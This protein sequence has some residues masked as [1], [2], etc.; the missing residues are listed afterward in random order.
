MAPCDV[1]V[2]I[3]ARV[4]S[5]QQ[6]DANTIGSQVEALKARVQTDGYVLDEELC[7]IDEGHSGGTL[8]R[9]ALERLR[10]QAAA[11]AVD[12]LY[13][14]S[15]DRLARNYPYQ[16]L[17]VDELQRQGVEITFLNHDIGRTPEEKLLLQVQGMVAEYER[18]KI[19]E[20]SRR[21]KRHA[22]RSGAVNVLSGAPY[23]YRYVGKYE[24]AGQ[25][26][27][28]VDDRQA[29]VVIQIFSWMALERCSLAEICRRLK[30]RGVPSPKGKNFW[31]RT[32]VWGLLQNRAYVGQAQFGK[33]RVGPSRPRLR[34]QRGKPMQP[35]RGGS[36]Y[37][38][39]AEERV[40]IPVPAIVSEDLFATVAEQLQE[41]RRRQRA[42]Q[43]GSRYLLQGLLVCGHCGY[44][45][46]GKPLSRSARKGKRRDYA[47]YRCV[48]TD[49]YR[50]G[51][52]RVCKNKQCRTDVLDQAVWEDVCGLLA[53][54]ERVRQEYERRLRGTKNKIGRPT[55]QLARL[56]AKTRQGLARLIDAYQEGYLEREEFEPRIAKTKERLSQLEKEAKL[57]AEREAESKDLGNVIGHL[58]SF[59]ERV[60]DGLK[61]AD[62][63]TRREILRALIKHVEV[64]EDVIRV[65]YKVSPVPFDRGPIRG[66][67]QDCWRGG[68]P[69]LRRPCFRGR[70]HPVVH[71]A[72]FQPLVDE[73]E[74][75]PV[76]HA[77]P[78]HR[79]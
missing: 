39:T 33:T 19:L 26:R 55:E 47:Y 17:L 11:G 43:R 24:G 28:E 58:Q 73:T 57:V 16:V 77:S 45:Y 78:Q 18:A 52:Q 48:G 61:D 44:A 2:A 14:H 42:S 41:N 69:A 50:F 8:L 63:S 59:A 23:G 68:H 34:P 35:R 10:D 38:T 15:P 22:A 6:A 29:E 20:R 51:G 5:K 25:A 7:F 67:S 49:A 72:R 30:D 46:Y 40:S 79:P 37:D 12:R 53:N 62:W 65:V 4:S 54:P 13:V 71:D 1:R 76:P 36:T 74:H 70:Q 60:R 31:D 64:G 9:P 27:Y 66:H 56:I 3:Y 32:T 21:G 75:N